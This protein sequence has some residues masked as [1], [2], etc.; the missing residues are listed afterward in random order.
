VCSRTFHFHDKST[1]VQHGRTG[2]LS[3]IQ[4]VRSCGRHRPSEYY[5]RTTISDRDKLTNDTPTVRRSPPTIGKKLAINNDEF[6]EQRYSPR[7]LEHREDA[8]ERSNEQKKCTDRLRAQQ[9]LESQKSKHSLGP[10]N[11]YYLLSCFC[12]LTARA[13]THIQTLIHTHT[14][15][16]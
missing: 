1:G 14:H 8:E 4:M 3:R 13:R 11:V 7:R 12:L 16:L 10:L 5:S 6:H 15:T 2:S 9:T